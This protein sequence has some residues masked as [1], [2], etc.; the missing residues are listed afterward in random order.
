VGDSHRVDRLLLELVG[1]DTPLVGG[2]QQRSSQLRM[3][4]SGKTFVIHRILSCPTG[5]KTDILEIIDR[6]IVTAVPSLA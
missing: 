4:G 5:S 1:I 6:Q 3:L 2:A